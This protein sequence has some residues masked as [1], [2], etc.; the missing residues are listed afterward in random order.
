MFFNKKKSRIILSDEK[1]NIIKNDVKLDFIPREN[2][3]L[4]FDDQKI[5]WLV[6]KVIYNISKDNTIWI[7]IVPQEN[8]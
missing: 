5:Y 1:F 3:L 8:F 7:I 2:E 6:L 4:F